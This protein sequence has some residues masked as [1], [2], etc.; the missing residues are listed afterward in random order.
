MLKVYVLNLNEVSS[1]CYVQ[2]CNS[3]CF[4]NNPCGLQCTSQQGCTNYCIQ[5]TCTGQC[6]NVCTGYTS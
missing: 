3:K 2:T 6:S 5:N 1:P 4:S